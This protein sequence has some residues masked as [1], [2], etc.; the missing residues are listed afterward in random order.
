[1]E[2]MKILSEVSV[3]AGDSHVLTLL[4]QPHNTWDFGFGDCED[5][6]KN[7]GGKESDV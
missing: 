7:I 5:F 3:G 6:Y 2:V 1:M 4:R